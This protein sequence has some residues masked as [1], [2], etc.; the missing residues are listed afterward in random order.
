[1]IR[2][3]LFFLLTA[4]QLWALGQNI[5]VKSFRVIQNDMDARINAP[6]KD[7]N[8]EICAIIK[9]V[10]TESDFT[11]DADQLG[12]VAIE[13]KTAEYW[14]YVPHGAKRLTIAHPKLGMLRNYIYP[15][16]IQVATVYEMVLTTGKITTI[17]EEQIESQFLVII[18]DPVEAKIYINDKFE[19][20]GTFQNKLKPGKYNYRVEASLYYTEA[21][22]IEITS[23]KK[24]LKITLKPNYGFISI[25]TK[26]EQ[27][28][29]IE[30]DGQDISSLTPFT[31]SKLKSGEH[32]YPFC[33]VHLFPLILPM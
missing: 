32:T 14:L 6:K 31:T 13:H 11:W 12:I 20:T 28:A 33:H 30:I 9:V 22:A 3:S 16:A 27:G 19:G 26:P 17:I 21:G 8:G 2:F 15:E 23:E 24:E 5:A 25:S 10:T 29:K 7:Q 1:M 4:F 18:T